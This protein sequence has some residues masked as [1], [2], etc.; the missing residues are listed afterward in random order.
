MEREHSKTL[1]SGVARIQD[2]LRQG[3]ILMALLTKAYS[4]YD[5]KLAVTPI[6]S[7][8]HN[9]CTRKS[10]SWLAYKYALWDSKTIEDLKD[11]ST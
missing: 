7:S 8:S 2:A 11:K 10:P 9:V 3:W 1:I 6:Q 4:L 5:V